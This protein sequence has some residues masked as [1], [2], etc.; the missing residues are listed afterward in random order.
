MASRSMLAEVEG[1]CEELG[2]RKAELERELSEVRGERDALSTGKAEAEASLKIA[3]EKLAISESSAEG[4]RSANDGLQS[5][6][7]EAEQQ[8]AHE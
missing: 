1:M 2:Q 7:D 3:G 5:D 4:L 8:V 6:L